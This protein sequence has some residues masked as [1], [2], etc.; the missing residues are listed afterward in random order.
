MR[1]SLG[2]MMSESTCCFSCSIPIAATF[3]RLPSKAKGLVTT[4]TVRMPMSRAISATTGA[5]P[6]P[7][8]PPMPAVMKSMSAPPISSLMRS[9]SSS[10]ARR[11]TSGLAPAPRP[12]VTSVPSCSVV[13]ARLRLSAWASV[14]IAMNS[15]PCTPL[16]IMWST[17]LPPQ[18]PTPTT[19]ITA[20]GVW[21][22]SS[23][24]IFLSPLCSTTKSKIPFEPALHPI[25]DFLE[26]RPLHLCVTITLHLLQPRHEQAH[27]GRISRVAHDFRE[28][29]VVIGQPHAHRHVEDLL[30]QLDHSLHEGGAA[31]DDDSRG[32][33]L[34][35][36]GAA[37]LALHQ[38]IELLHPGLDHF[39]ERLARELARAAL[40]RAAQLDHVRR[41]RELP[42]GHAVGH[43]QFLGVLG[44]RAQ[45]HGD[46]VGDLVAG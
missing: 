37:Q 39:R 45:R 22:S 29:P 3:W 46:V 23:S 31:G 10:A 17:A 5:A 33:Q 21:L 30:A 2:M 18:P 9:R 4:A 36:A 7:V 16:L 44:R 26:A 35:E 8:P 15:T 13:F 27:G 42:K 28:R 43:L 20:S 14:F 32:E 40:A 24:I 1:R 25:E 12:L 38:R 6:V 11:P 34:L 19:L 41:A